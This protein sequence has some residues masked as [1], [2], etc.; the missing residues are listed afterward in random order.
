MGPQGGLC[1]T[2]TESAVTAEG[3]RRRKKTENDLLEALKWMCYPKY[4]VI[5]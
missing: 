5:L 2:H 1:C 4:S 3:E